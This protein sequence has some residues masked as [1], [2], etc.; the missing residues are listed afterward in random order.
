MQAAC[1]CFFY[2]RSLIFLQLDEN[3]EEASARNSRPWINNPDLASNGG[4]Q[5]AAWKT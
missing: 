4:E 5:G 2:E 3:F 1:H